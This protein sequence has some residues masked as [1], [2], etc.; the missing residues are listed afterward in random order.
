MFSKA[1]L[2]NH[3]RGKRQYSQFVS[4]TAMAIGSPSGWWD[5]VRL[6]RGKL[7]QLHN[8]YQGTA[9]RPLAGYLVVL[10]TYTSTTAGLAVL[11]KKLGK[12]PPPPTFIDTA[13]MT[14]AT[15]KLSRLLSKDAIT[16]P[17]RAP[18]ARYE[19]PTGDAEVM[20]SVQG[21]GV[22]HAA[23]ELLTCPFCLAVWVA[24]CLGAGMVFAPG[25]TRL[26]CTIFTAVAGSD[27]LQLA[28]DL[29]KQRAAES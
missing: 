19:K 27:V 20:E 25:L 2:G 28:Y 21:Q 9:H 24:T 18:F 16:S 26:V 7:K 17:L 12:K 10:A 4:E 1:H 6:L 15:H 5:I 11:A 13:L 8:D 14:V 3:Q 29:A 23:G 22:R